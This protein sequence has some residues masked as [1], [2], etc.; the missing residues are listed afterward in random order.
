MVST[1]PSIDAVISLPNRHRWVSMTSASWIPVKSGKDTDYSGFQVSFPLLPM[2]VEGRATLTW[3]KHLFSNIM[4]CSHAVQ[5]VELLVIITSL[6]YIVVQPVPLRDNLAAGCW[7]VPC[8]GQGAGVIY[9]RAAF[10]R[11][12]CLGTHMGLFTQNKLYALFATYC[13]FQWIES[14]AFAFSWPKKK[15]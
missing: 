11:A 3:C 5:M 7:S 1:V 15:H 2:T 8:G 13:L 6:V 12:V 9:I 4:R 14:T 10:S